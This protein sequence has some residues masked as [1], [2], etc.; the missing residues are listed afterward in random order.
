MTVNSYLVDVE[1]SVSEV[2][3]TNGESDL[4]ELIDID[5]GTAK[6]SSQIGEFS[7]YTSSSSIDKNLN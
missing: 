4:E 2:K 1:D 7:P 3:E 5:C 6:S